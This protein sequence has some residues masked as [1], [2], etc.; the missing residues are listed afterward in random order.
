VDLSPAEVEAR[1]YR[2][3]P[4]FVP[5]LL[6]AAKRAGLSLSQPFVLQKDYEDLANSWRSH[7]DL[8][9]LA[10]QVLRFARKELR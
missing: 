7:R 2:A 3:L 4:V 10:H 6:H 8:S 5:K 1:G 9:H